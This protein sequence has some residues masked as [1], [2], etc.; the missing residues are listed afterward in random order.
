MGIKQTVIDVI[1]IPWCFIEAPEESYREELEG[2]VPA[3]CG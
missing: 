1:H 2:A 3:D